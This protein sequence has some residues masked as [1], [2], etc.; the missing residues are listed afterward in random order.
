MN[1]LH[2]ALA[3]SAV[4]AVALPIVIHLL[5]RRRRVPVDWAAMELLREAIRRTNRRL[6]VEQ[7]IVLALRSLAVLAAGLALAVPFL[8][9]GAVGSAQERTWIVVVDNGATSA[10]RAGRGSELDRLRD[11]VRAMLEADRAQGDRYGIVTAAI[12]AQ[13]VLGP[14]TDLAEFE[15]VLARIEPAE[16]PSDLSGAIDAATDVVSGSFDGAGSLAAD[17][18][19]AGRVLVASAFRRASLREGEVFGSAASV[20]EPEAADIDAVNAVSANGASRVEMIAV[21]P[22]TD[23]PA[24]VSIRRIETRAMPS[25]GTQVVRIELSREGAEL[26]AATT[27]VR[28]A[29]E[30][31]NAVAPREVRWEAGQPY[32]EVELQIAPASSEAGDV[33]A[34]RQR[35]P[36]TVSLD[37]DALAVG[38]SAYAVIDL[39]REIEVAVVGRRGTLDGADIEK[40]PGSLWISRALAPGMGAGGGMRV[41]E[42]DPASCDARA[43]LGLDAVIVARP[44]LLSQQ[45]MEALA[46]FVREG[47]LLVLVPAGESTSQT[48]ASAFLPRLGVSARIDP[49]VRTSDP[50]LRL[51]DEQPPSRLLASIVPELPA[52][53]APVESGRSVRLADVAGDEVIL[54]FEDGT[55]FVVAQVPQIPAA[56]A[57]GALEVSGSNGGTATAS[58]SAASPSSSRRGLVVCIA[59]SP[60]LAWTNL[61]VK[62]LMVPLFQEVVRMGLE[63]SRGGDSVLVGEPLRASDGLFRLERI[64]RTAAAIETGAS[65]VSREIV[66]VAGIWRSDTDA[67]VAANVR[68][69]SIATTPSSSEAVRVA[70]ARLG[71]VRIARQ[72]TEAAGVPTT[73]PHASGWSFALLVVALA[74]L[75]LEGV[76]SRIFSHASMMRA[77]GRDGGIVA[78]GRVRRPGGARAQLREAAGSAQERVGTGGS[79]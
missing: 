22:A 17:R 50:G 76:L 61:P 42:I 28:V 68:T 32:T 62:P 20:G 5:F 9:D 10:L 2:P 70:F 12:P 59:S 3:W 55:P 23:A 25:G 67:M 47:R 78:V 36:V 31:W 57:S 27:R 43:L 41:R 15:R 64:D 26:D 40:V 16:T 54:A 71:G 44:D 21:A 65:G 79:A 37:D 66:P 46:A 45:S 73:Q 75:L 58:P 52:L 34:R 18:A 8:G 4:G 30:G 14:T 24:D 49:E 51:R 48:W 60:E 77:G 69:E 1:F 39:R 53:C 35:L 74:A 6:R 38:N 29:G 13:L 56:D 63:I 19:R 33:T 72:S 11:E 7:W